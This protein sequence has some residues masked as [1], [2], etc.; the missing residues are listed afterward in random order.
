MGG[1]ETYFAHLILNHKLVCDSASSTLVDLNAP[2][3]TIIKL[4]RRLGVKV[5]VFEELGSPIV[6]VSFAVAAF[7]SQVAPRVFQLKEA[8]VLQKGE[9]AAG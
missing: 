7:P 4:L 3:S 2:Q 8:H 9:V 6:L 5:E 1:A